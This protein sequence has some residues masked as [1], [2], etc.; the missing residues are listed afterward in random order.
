MNTR[1]LFSSLFYLLCIGV[2]TKV[3]ADIVVF[4]V[5]GTSSLALSGNASPGG[6]NFPYQNQGGAAS[7][8]T[9]YLGT[10]TVNVDNVLGPSTI[11][12]QSANLTANLNSIA[13]LSPQVGGGAAGAPG[14]APA[15]YGVTIPA[16]GGVGA[17]RDIAFNIASANTGVAGGAFSVTN[18]VWS[19]NPG[20]SFDVNAPALG[21]GRVDLRVTSPTGL[22][23][24]TAGSYTV[25]GNTATLVLPTAVSIL[26][27]DGLT[28]T[29]TYNGTITAIAAVPEPSS[30]AL[31]CICGI[32]G[33]LV[34]YRK[35]RLSV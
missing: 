11:S 27:N 14:S 22:N 6:N 3:Q 4:N 12:F 34:R 8:T 18:Q 19:Y 26:F 32:G 31:L 29:N 5:V 25:V 28:G 2:F 24:G 30:I 9:T 1:F 35:R 16:V 15:N 7:L 10:I 13:N 23:T 20:S 33:A 17:L 21:Q